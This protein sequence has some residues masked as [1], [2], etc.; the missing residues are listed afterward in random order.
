MSP[1]PGAAAGTP[2][3]TRTT[4][5][6]WL[7]TYADMITLL[8]ALFMVLFS[9]SSVNISKYQTLQQSLK[10]A[11]SGDILPGRRSDRPARR[12]RRTRAMRP[13]AID[14]QAIVPVD[15]RDQRLQSIQPPTAL[16]TAPPAAP[17]AASSSRR[18]AQQRRPS[19]PCSPRSSSSS[20]T[21]PPRT[22]SASSVQADD[23]TTRARHQGAHR[24]AAVPV[25]PGRRSSSAPRSLLTEIATLA[26]RR[27][28]RT[29]S[30][31]KGNTDNVPIHSAQFPSNWELSSGPRRA[32]SS[33]S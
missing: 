6:R 2:P 31:S 20:T 15:G 5:E 7:L 8:M 28:A 19:Q 25:R 22:A 30:T 24:R 29:R 26:E 9:I 32:P 16:P 17:P 27:R 4:P 10:A 1:L 33:G 21:T 23:R 18:R 13:D 14:L 11:F 3:N 12:D